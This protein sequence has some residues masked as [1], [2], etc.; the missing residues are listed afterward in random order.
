MRNNAVNADGSAHEYTNEPCT[1]VDA[2]SNERKTLV[3]D[4]DE[5]LVHSALVCIGV[6]DFAFTVLLHIGGY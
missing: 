2:I 6:A 3:L 1:L 4:L 5:T